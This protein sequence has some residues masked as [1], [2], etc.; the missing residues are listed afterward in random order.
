VACGVPSSG[1]RGFIL[2]NHSYLGHF[3]WQ[4]LQKGRGNFDAAV[5]TPGCLSTG[6]CSASVQCIPPDGDYAGVL[7]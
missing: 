4:G 3:T 5:G 7:K 2:G 6:D 1:R